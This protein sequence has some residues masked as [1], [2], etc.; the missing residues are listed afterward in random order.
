MK[1]APKS[2]NIATA[3]KAEL[4]RKLAEC[5]VFIKA[6]G[7]E[8]ARLEALVKDSEEQI[9]LANEAAAALNLEMTRQDHVHQDELESISA[10][11]DKLLTSQ[12]Q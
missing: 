9:K 3:S 12:K 2:I 1:Q 10:K 11:L 8:L 5:A 6:C 7:K 4:V